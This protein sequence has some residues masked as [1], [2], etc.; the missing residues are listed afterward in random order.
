MNFFIAFVPTF[1]N[2]QTIRSIN[3][4]YIN[5]CLQQ[6]QV[7]KLPNAISANKSKPI[8]SN[9]CLTAAI[10]MITSYFGKMNYTTTNTDTLKKYLTSDPDVS[11]TVNDNGTRIG[12]AYAVTS[13]EAEETPGS[14]TTNYADGVIKYA[15]LKGLQSSGLIFIPNSS[16]VEMKNFIYNKVKQAIDRGNPVLMSTKTHGRVAVGYTSNGNII[17]HDSFRDTSI[18]AGG[19]FS[20]NGKNASFNIPYAYRSTPGTAPE[21]FWYLIEFS[22]PNPRSNGNKIAENN[23]LIELKKQEEIKKKQEEEKTKLDEQERFK[24]E[25]KKQEEDRLKKEQETFKIEKDKLAK[26]NELEKEKKK[27][28]ELEESKWYNQVKNYFLNFDATV[29]FLIFGLILVFL[30]LYL[31][32]FRTSKTKN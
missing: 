23:R 30:F 9:M 16:D 4:P 14:Y 29:L 25:Q 20:Y 21:K 10:L 18:A 13:M 6:D 28:S 1:S 24:Q 26:A 7:T 3:V 12:G 8:C 32:F 2:A 27:D 5:Q 22:D 31:L 11:Y 19:D 17:A 15:K